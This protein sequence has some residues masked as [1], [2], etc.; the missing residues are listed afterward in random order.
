MLDV[1][2]PTISG[3]QVQL[4]RDTH[5]EL[6]KAPPRAAISREVERIFDLLEAQYHT[7]RNVETGR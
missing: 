1:N 4:W 2:R 5:W 6:I 7:Q 3:T